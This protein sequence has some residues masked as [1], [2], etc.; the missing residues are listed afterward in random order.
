MDHTDSEPM[1]GDRADERGSEQVVARVRSLL[2]RGQL[3]R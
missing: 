3:R 2:E 1:I